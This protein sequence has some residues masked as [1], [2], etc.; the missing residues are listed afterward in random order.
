MGIYRTFKTGNIWKLNIFKVGFNVYPYMSPVFQYF[1]TE[2]TVLYWS[3]KHTQNGN[4]HSTKLDVSEA[5]RVKSFFHFI[6]T[7]AR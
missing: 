6:P 7:Q 3:Q 5:E 4:I 1:N 2:A